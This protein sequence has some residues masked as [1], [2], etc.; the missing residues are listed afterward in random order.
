MK[1]EKNC[2]NINRFFF[3]I[4]L[5][6]TKLLTNTLS[7]LVSITLLNINNTIL[8][9]FTVLFLLSLPQFVCLLF[10]F[11]MFQNIVPFLKLKPINLLIFLLYSYFIFKTIFDKFI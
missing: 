4:K 8:S 7:V 3:L 6:L 5:P 11:R 1:N 9:H 2:Q 10:Y